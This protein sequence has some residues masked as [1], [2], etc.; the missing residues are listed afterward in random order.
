MVHHN[1]TG[2][3]M[4]DTE[5]ITLAKE[6]Q[7]RV[8][9]HLIQGYRLRRQGLGLEQYND[10]VRYNAVADNILGEFTTLISVEDYS[11]T[12]DLNKR[13]VSLE[14]LLDRIKGF[15]AG[16][17]KEAV[18]KPKVRSLYD[19]MEWLN[20]EVGDLLD[21]YTEREGNVTIPKSYAGFF[22]GK[23]P[24]SAQLKSD[25]D[26]YESLFNKAK[27]E[28]NRQKSIMRDIGRKFERFVGNVSH[29]DEFVKLLKE[30]DNKQ[31]K[32][33][34]A[35]FSNPSHKFMGFGKEPFFD[36]GKFEYTAPDVTSVVEIKLP[37]PSKDELAS[38]VLQLRVLCEFY[39]IADDY[40]SDYPMGIDPTDPPLRGY[41]DDDEVQEFVNRSCYMMEVFEDYNGNFPDQL[42]DRIAE[43]F[44]AMTVYLEH[45]LK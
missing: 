7:K 9:K 3:I 34:A 14:G 30:I 42:V 35:K 40:A 13:V 12:E 22:T 23:G 6:T 33:L 43:L 1:N 45:V 2:V 20:N 19:R 24:L 44:T 8:R 5:I 36:R 37:Y 31:T 28:L 27:S 29:R 21:T 17:K 41:M 4:R 38:F 16:K 26:Q 25:V 18:N 39:A 10:I 32:G 11:G 15:L